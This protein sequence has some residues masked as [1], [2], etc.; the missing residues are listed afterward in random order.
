MGLDRFYSP[1]Q[2]STSPLSQ[3][4]EGS[5]N[6]GVTAFFNKRIDADGG[7]DCRLRILIDRVDKA[8]SRSGPTPRAAQDVADR[9]CRDLVAEFLSLP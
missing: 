9:H 8:Q 7:G 6:P 3:Y 4:S 5:V 2:R 1:I